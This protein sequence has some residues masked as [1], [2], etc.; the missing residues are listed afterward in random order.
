ML[1]NFTI[2]TVGI[3]LVLAAAAVHVQGAKTSAR[4]AVAMESHVIHR[5]TIENV[6]ADAR[7]IRAWVPVP[8]SNDFQKITNISVEP[9]GG[10]LKRDPVYGNLLMY[11]EWA[12]T[13]AK[14]LGGKNVTISIQYDLVRSE[15]KAHQEPAPTE[16]AS[17]RFLEGDARAPINDRVKEFAAHATAGKTT[18]MERARGIYDFVLDYMT[19]SKEGVG[20]GNGDVKWACDSKRGNCSDFHALFISMAR[21]VGIPARFHYGY[22]LKPDGTT[23]AHCWAQFLDASNGWVPVDISEA[24]KVVDKEPAKRDYFFGTLTTNRVLLSTGRDLVLE[25]KQDGSPLN[26]IHATYV[27]VDGKAVDAKMDVTHRGK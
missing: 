26:F 21:S 18:T 14:P 3:S 5:A 23:A 2:V 4:P 24:D 6:A 9:A 20:W 13:A 17:K 12:S 19:Y 15:E 27:E 22:S 16:A 8:A 25:P 10:E 11:F 1:Q 7:R